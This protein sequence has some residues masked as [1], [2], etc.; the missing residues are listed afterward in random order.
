MSDLMSFQIGFEIYYFICFTIE[1]INLFWIEIIALLHCFDTKTIG[2][3]R[4]FDM[5]WLKSK[6]HV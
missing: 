1:T 3:E 4:R 5:Q 6:T 2:T